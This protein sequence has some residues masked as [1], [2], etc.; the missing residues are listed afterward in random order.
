MRLKGPPNT[1]CLR[2]S[3]FALNWGHVSIGASFRCRLS[4]FEQRHRT[5][6]FSCI[7]ARMCFL[8]L[9]RWATSI[10]H[11]IRTQHCIVR[12]SAT[13]EKDKILF[14]VAEATRFGH[15]VGGQLGWRGG[16]SLRESR[17]WVVQG[18]C[19][20]NSGTSLQGID[21]QHLNAPGCGRDNSHTVDGQSNNRLDRSPYRKAA[22]SS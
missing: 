9:A 22:S 6:T 2:P 19:R 1:D 7:T 5:T 3:G 11:Q 8:S 12:G 17:P 16:I 20:W 18:S 21:S 14:V 4:S 10:W 15:G 13:L